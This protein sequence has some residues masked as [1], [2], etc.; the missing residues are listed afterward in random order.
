MAYD[1]K[2]Q[3]VNFDNSRPLL[4]LAAATGIIQSLTDDLAT[5]GYYAVSMDVAIAAE[6]LDAADGPVDIWIKARDWTLAEFEEYLELATSFS[7]VD[8]R[9]KEIG[10]RGTTIKHIGMITPT[11]LALNDGKVMRVK[12]GIYVPEGQS[13]DL[14]YYNS[15]DAVM[16]TG[17]IVSASGKM[18]GRWAS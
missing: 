6:Q 16:T 13:L 8:L 2:F 12:L 17:C 3:V 15:N 18:Y 7:R 11:E 1:K 14:V 4:T 5:E 10:R 9:Q